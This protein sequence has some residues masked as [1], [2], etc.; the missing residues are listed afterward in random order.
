MTG[1]Y[2]FGVFL[3]Q[4]CVENLDF[5]EFEGQEGSLLRQIVECG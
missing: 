4:P 1:G 2:F 5:F 3:L